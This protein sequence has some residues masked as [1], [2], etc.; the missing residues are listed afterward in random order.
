MRI[1]LATL[2]FIFMMFFAYAIAFHKAMEHNEPSGPKSYIEIS[3]KDYEELV[4]KA[5]SAP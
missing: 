2:A 5:M 3:V 4:K 1:V